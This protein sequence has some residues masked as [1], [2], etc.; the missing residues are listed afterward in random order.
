MR[1]KPGS[2]SLR[3]YNRWQVDVGANNS[4]KRILR[5][6]SSFVSPGGTRS[7][8]GVGETWPSKQ[9]VPTGREQLPDTLGMRLMTREHRLRYALDR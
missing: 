6:L 9:A 4:P 3:Y 8:V 1:G 5:Q 2:T 7:S